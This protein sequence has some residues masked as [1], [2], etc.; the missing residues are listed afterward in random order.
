MRPAPLT[1][2]FSGWARIHAKDGI[3]DGVIQDPLQCNF[4]P[5]T[6]LASK[7]CPGNV[8]AEACFTAAQVQTIQ[9]IYGGVRDSRGVGFQKDGT[10]VFQNL[11][12]L[13]C[14]LTCARL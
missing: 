13:S 12:P 3:R 2:G 4:D 6:D 5:K 14:S 11:S 1:F 7:M 9:D 8:N 10:L